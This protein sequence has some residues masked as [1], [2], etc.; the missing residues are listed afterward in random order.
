MAG[1]GEQAELET[2]ARAGGQPPLGRGEFS[3]VPAV[4]V[5]G[6][7]RGITGKLGADLC[8]AL[9]QAARGLL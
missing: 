2:A 8:G 9:V 1:V 7:P 4:Q 3:G 6:Q 5:R